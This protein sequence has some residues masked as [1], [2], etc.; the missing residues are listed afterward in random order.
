MVQIDHTPADLILVNPIERHPIGRRWITVAI[1]LFSR[2]IAGFHVTLEAPSATS[3]GLCL[4]H[5]ASDKRPWLKEIGFD[6]EWP[7]TRR[8]QRGR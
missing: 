8:P 6:A 2:C 1:H 3:V 7:V 4:A 5:I